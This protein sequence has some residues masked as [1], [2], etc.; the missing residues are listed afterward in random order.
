[1]RHVIPEGDLLIHAG[2]ITRQGKLA[3][4]G[5]IERFFHSLP[6][7]HKIFIPGNHDWCFQDD[8]E[9]SRAAINSATCLIDEE[10]DVFGLRIW[11]SPWQPDFHS[12]AFN[13]PR[14]KALA[15]R[16]KLIPDDTDILITHGP[17][18]GILDLCSNGSHEGC[19]DL[20][21]RVETISPRL[22]VFGHIHEGHGVETHG[23]ITF[24]NASICNLAYRPVNPPIVIDL[25][26]G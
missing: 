13:L 7:P 24:V 18:R 11:G 10:I 2:D 9:P 16:W 4:L 3:D 6:H 17:P 12:W 20:R 14:G 22:H 8:P 23:G 15:D 1:M 5:E 25:A 26:T 21:E 19:E